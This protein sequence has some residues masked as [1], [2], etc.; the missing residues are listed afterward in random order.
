[1]A[2]QDGGS[3]KQD[4]DQAPSSLQAGTAVVA[5]ERGLW[6]AVGPGPCPSGSPPLL[7]AAARAGLVSHIGVS[8]NFYVI[9]VNVI[10][11]NYT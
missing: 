2:L 3:L 5:G 4:V 6:I 11:R 7:M 8:V 1:M 9:T 10:T